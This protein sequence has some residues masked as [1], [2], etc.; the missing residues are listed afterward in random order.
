M[1]ERVRVTVQYTLH[2]TRNTIHAGDTL[3]RAS[4]GEL[5]SYHVATEEAKAYAKEGQG[6][7]GCLVVSQL[8]LEARHW[9]YTKGGAFC[10]V[11]NG[12][13]GRLRDLSVFFGCVS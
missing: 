10:R 11:R 13:T 2:N 1:I 8:A 7:F 6:C 3:T 4:L 12:S 9:T 5:M